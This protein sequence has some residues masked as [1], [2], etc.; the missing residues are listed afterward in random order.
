MEAAG[1]EPDGDSFTVIII[2]WCDGKQPGYPLYKKLAA[3][4]P[5]S[6]TIQKIDAEISRLQSQLKEDIET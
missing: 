3:E 2:K 6:K 1:I 5:A 4:E